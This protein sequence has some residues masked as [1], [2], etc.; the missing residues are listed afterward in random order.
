MTI[1]AP[2][3]LSVVMNDHNPFDTSY[4]CALSNNDIGT[5]L[6]QTPSEVAGSS[7]SSY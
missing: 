5:T 1:G 3:M 7:T 2:V 4:H 6:Y